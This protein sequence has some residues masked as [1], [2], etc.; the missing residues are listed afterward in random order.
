MLEC[1]KS[2]LQSGSS[3][4]EL[5]LSPSR[6]ASNRDRL[7]SDETNPSKKNVFG[8]LAARNPSAVVGSGVGAV[9]TSAGAALASVGGSGRVLNPLSAARVSAL[10]FSLL[11][12]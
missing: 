10:H 1:R 8:S 6:I 11:N 3:K 9:T 4:A 12:C 7:G 5:E 2:F